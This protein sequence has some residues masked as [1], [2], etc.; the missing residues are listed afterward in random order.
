MTSTNLPTVKMEEGEEK[1]LDPLAAVYVKEEKPFIE[2]K[3]ETGNI[4]VS[5]Q[6]LRYLVI[7]QT[8]K[9]C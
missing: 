1:L 2:I 8:S 6:Y 5:F 3:V 9:G 4:Y 7:K